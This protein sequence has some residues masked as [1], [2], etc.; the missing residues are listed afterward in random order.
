[1]NHFTSLSLFCT[2]VAQSTVPA[3]APC[4]FLQIL[5]KLLRTLVPAVQDPAF[6]SS[7]HNF[8]DN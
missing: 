7:D 6:P 4:I 5:F 8:K 1:M 3:A 2:L